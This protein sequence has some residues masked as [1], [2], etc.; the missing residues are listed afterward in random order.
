MPLLVLVDFHCGRIIEVYGAN[1]SGK[2]SLITSVCAQ[3]QRLFPDKLVAIIDIEQAFDPAYAETLGLDLSE[4]RL[5]FTQPDGGVQA[6]DIYE[7]LVESGVF[8]IVVLDSVAALTT[9]REMAADV[10]DQLMAEVPRMVGRFLKKLLPVAKKTETLC[11]FVNQTRSNIG[12]YGGGDITTGGAAF[13]FYASMRVKVRKK[14]LLTRGSETY[15]QVQVAKFEKNKCG[16]PYRE[17]ETILIFNKGYDPYSELVD[18]A[19][20]KKLIERG[21]AWYTLPTTAGDHRLMGKVA[22]AA[23]YED[24]LAEFEFLKAK[25]EE[26]YKAVVV[27]DE[28]DSEILNAD[29]DLVDEVEVSE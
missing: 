17:A 27:M 15:A 24:N 20:D 25:L 10:G 4:E 22:V 29:P 13:K 5:L 2:T 3:A 11:I 7:K 16:A 14:E 26:S 6:L 12:S 9:D 23:F 8:S 18:V 19:I 28:D 21:G 1:S